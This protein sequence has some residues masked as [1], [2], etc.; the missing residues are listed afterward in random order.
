MS[1]QLKKSLHS[2]FLNGDL[3][4]FVHERTACEVFHIHNDD[5][6]NLFMF[7]VP[8]YVS[9]S[10]GVAHI[11][12][13]SVL[14]GSERYTVKSPFFRLEQGSCRTYLNASTYP[15]RTLYPG[16]SLLKED[17]FNI[18]AMSGDAV[19]FPLLRED[20]FRQEG[21]HF[22]FDE[23][24]NT[25]AAGVVF[26][27]MK[28]AYSD[29]YTLIENYIHEQLFPDMEYRFDSGGSPLNI[30]DLTYEEFVAYHKKYYRPEHT[31]IVVYGNID[32]HEHLNFID[33]EL[34]SRWNKP[35]Q[36]AI[37]LQAYQQKKDLTRPASGSV[38]HQE[39][40]HKVEIPSSEHAGGEEGCVEI[41]W[42]IGNSNDMILTGLLQVVH[43]VL[44]GI[45][46][47]LL[48]KKI[49]QSGLVDD[50]SPLSGAST[51][52]QQS[53]YSVGG[54]GISQENYQSFV[55]LVFSTLQEIVAQG[56]EEKL[57][58]AA[59]SRI[60]FSFKERLNNISG[61]VRWM[62]LLASKWLYK[63]DIFEYADIPAILEKI[64][65][66][67]KKPR[68]IEDF[69]QLYLVKNTHRVITGAVPNVDYEQTYRNRELESL[70]SKLRNT[71]DREFWKNIQQKV[72]LY[73]RCPDDE[74]AI[75]KIPQLRK[76]SLPKEII[77]IP[78]D[79]E[80]LSLDSYSRKLPLQWIPHIENGV[81]YVNIHF[82]ITD[83]V[84]EQD[85]RLIMPTFAAS[86]SE[87]GVESVSYDDFSILVCLHTGRL[88][89]EI[90]NYI[91]R[92]G[93][94]RAFLNIKVSILEEQVENGFNL[95]Q[96]ILQETDFN[97]VKRLKEIMS[98][99]LTMIRNRLV[100]SG[101][102]LAIMQAAKNYSFN[103]GVDSDWN[104]LSQ[105]EWLLDSSNQKELCKK[106][107][108]LT[109]RIFCKERVFCTAMGSPRLKDKVESKI[110]N[111]LESLPTTS[112]KANKVQDNFES[113]IFGVMHRAS[114]NTTVHSRQAI[115]LPTKV[116]YNAMIIPAV[117]YH[118]PDYAFHNIASRI[119]SEKLLEEI[120]MEYGAYGASAT[121]LGDE[122]L[123]VCYTYRDPN[124]TESF[125]V[126]KKV[127]R[128]VA[129]GNFNELVLDSHIV[130]AV[131]DSLVQISPL[132][133]IGLLST[134]L[135]SGI[136]D[137]VRQQIRDNLLSATCEDIRRVAESYIDNFSKISVASVCNEEMAKMLQW[138]KI[139]FAPH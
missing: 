11:L 5:P 20:V 54:A 57:L 36:D 68:A 56:V 13:H 45:P 122:A 70:Q 113:D 34:L 58:Q 85:L 96:K 134:R 123:L 33:M 86:L 49:M 135:V 101:T 14:S 25:R 98:E 102:T 103:A 44:L 128:N 77:Y 17:L 130:G 72:E 23:Y 80:M 40:I 2:T 136:D 67:L 8:S 124:I 21:F 108:N 104:G 65:T 100:E 52:L 92:N 41:S 126:F 9:D 37:P 112:Q 97:N 79:K 131:G 59:L 31:K 111:V 75:K 73:H 125:E 15:D 109:Q 133:K 51:Y 99:G 55:D 132:A 91:H 138:D 28:G 66:A 127:I 74:E 6:E 61:K 121:V 94:S 88:S 105:L 81:C 38:E 119:I 115:I 42:L 62:S 64:K 90:H 89:V 120:R 82:D 43:F 12:E 16:A 118:H 117:G 53:S 50:I 3:K 27:E 78:Y 106:L 22:I 129:G 26:N 71:R 24:D 83:L 93:G 107:Q 4:F 35:K 84:L 47:A 19:F 110:Q 116:A 1:F 29:K 39:F 69:I 18:M 87:I 139:E 46:G 76:S 30:P 32:S 7:A 137:E 63:E 60:E 114:T 48:R 95:I 10:T